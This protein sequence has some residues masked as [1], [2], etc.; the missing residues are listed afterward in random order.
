MVNRESCST[1]ATRLLYGTVPAPDLRREPRALFFLHSDIINISSFYNI[2]VTTGERRVITFFTMLHSAANR[3]ARPY[4][5][6]R[7][8]STKYNFCMYRYNIASARCTQHVISSFRNV[9]KNWATIAAR[10]KNYAEK[11]RTATTER[12]LERGYLRSEANSDLPMFSSRRRA[13][14]RSINSTSNNHSKYSLFL[15]RS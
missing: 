12:L 1:V 14:L 7:V 6:T 4:T 3:R 15:G 11:K 5:C 2:A 10:R 13:K 8:A 9:S